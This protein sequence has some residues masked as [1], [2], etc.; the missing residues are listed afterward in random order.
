MWLVAALALSF[1]APL[2]PVKR[3]QTSGSHALSGCRA[4][5]ARL[6]LSSPFPSPELPAGPS[7]IGSAYQSSSFPVR[8]MVFVDGSWLY[9]SFHGRRQNCPVTKTYGTGWE[10]SHSIAYE[11]LTQLI[12]QYVHDEL[13]RRHHTNRFVEVVRTVVFSSMRSDTHHRSTRMR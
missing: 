4:Q 11:R 3:S 6:T 10:Y 12:S 13:L 9:Y 5:A 1:F 2:A 8:V 7:E